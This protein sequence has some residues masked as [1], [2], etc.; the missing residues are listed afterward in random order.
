[1]HVHR[2]VGQMRMQGP[3]SMH[4]P[5]A[6][7]LMGHYCMD[8]C[9][10]SQHTNIP[11]QEY[12]AHTHLHE[13]L[14]AHLPEPLIPLD[15][16]HGAGGNVSRGALQTVEMWRSMHRCS[17]DVKRDRI[18]RF[19]CMA[20]CLLLVLCLL[21]WCWVEACR[22]VQRC[23]EACNG[24]DMCACAPSH[25]VQDPSGN[26]CMHHCIQACKRMHACK[27]R[28]HILSMPNPGL[29]QAAPGWVC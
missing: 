5:W 24:V 3:G 25:A 13:Q 8:R 9:T 4:G 14:V 16:K 6:H 22:G 18:L 27:Q 12:P 10:T 21:A 19:A 15:G 26:A 23:V 2:C 20:L 29:G 7:T 28:R 1:M 17:L 11:D